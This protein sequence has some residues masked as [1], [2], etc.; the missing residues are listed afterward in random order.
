MAK[1]WAAW[2]LRSKGEFTAAL[3]SLREAEIRWSRTDKEWPLLQQRTRQVERLVELE[4][5]LPAVLGGQQKPANV[6]ELLE[7]AQLCRYEGLHHTSA[8]LYAAA[9]ALDPKR[10]NDPRANYR[11]NAARAAAAAGT[12]TSASIGPLQEEERA[13]C[14]R[15]A[16]D[17]L[18][19][20][21]AL[22]T[23]YLDSD[24]PPARALVRDAIQRWRHVPE[25]TGVRAPHALAELREVER[26]G[27]RKFWADVDALLVRARGPSP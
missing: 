19:A 18:R 22:L 17:W 12:G 9:F 26:D 11:T 1:S 27:W 7:Y 3:A 14:R 5:R 13:R 24:K 16:R 6:G 2:A 4:R 8:R 15:Q 21:L 23:K 10:V 25:L 20:D